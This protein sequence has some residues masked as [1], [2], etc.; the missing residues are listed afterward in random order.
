MNYDGTKV[1]GVPDGLGGDN[2]L[3]PF[4]DVKIFASGLLGGV[5][6]AEATEQAIQGWNRVCGIRLALVANAGEAHIVVTQGRIDGPMGTLAWSELPCGFT[7]NQWRKLKQ[8][9]DTGEMWTIAENPP[10][11][12]I[13]AV[14]VLRH[15]IGHAIGISH[16]AA[17]NLMAPTYSAS[18]RDVQRGDVLEAVSRYGK[19][20]AVPAPVPAPSVPTTP[21]PNLPGMGR[22]TAI[23]ILDAEGRPWRGDVQW[24]P[25]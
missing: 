17:G 3:W 13:D 23:E 7:P 18:I 22:V 9:Y 24:K 14:R 20:A 16:I 15:E 1:C 6:L 21:V 10:G 12:K 5:D 8:Q 4:A 2:C 11:N 25:L 19:P